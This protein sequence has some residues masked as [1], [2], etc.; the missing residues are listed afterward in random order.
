MTKRCYNVSHFERGTGFPLGAC[1]LERNRVQFSISL[2]DETDGRLHIVLAN[3]EEIVI[4]IED[5]YCVGNIFSVVVELEDYTSCRYYYEN[6]GKIMEDAYAKQ[7]LGREKWGLPIAKEKLS[8]K[9]IDFSNSTNHNIWKSRSFS[10]TV[11]YR[12]HVRGFTKDPSSGVKARGTFRG[13][14]EK[15]PYLK[16]LG[17]NAVELMPCYEFNEIN[18]CMSPRH[19]GISSSI[20]RPYYNEEIKWKLNYWGYAEDNFYFAPK[21]SYC[22]DPS[23]SCAEFKD[24]VD[25]LHK[26]DI[27]VYMEF[28]FGY[29][30]NQ[31]LIADCL[32]FWQTVYQIDGFKVNQDWIPDKLLATDPILNQVKLF[33]QNWNIGEYYPDGRMPKRKHLADDNDTFMNCARRFLKGDEEQVLAFSNCMKANPE[34]K[35]VVNYL[36]NTNSMTLM[37]M[38]SYDVKHND[39]NGENGMDGTNYNFSWNCGFEGK[40]RKKAVLELR[41]KQIK[42]AFI[43]LFFSQGTP[44]LLAGDEFG[45]SQEGNNNPYCLD[46][47]I[48]WVNWNE[49]NKNEWMFEFVK[50]CIHFRKKHKILHMEEQ[51]KAMDYISCG[52][53]DVS[54]HGLQTWYPDYTN[55]SRI[56]GVMLCGKYAKLD[57]IKFDKDFYIAYNFHWESHEFCLPNSLKGKNWTVILNTANETEQELIEGT[58]VVKEKS[59]IIPSRTVVVFMEE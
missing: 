35:S 30:T 13:L 22:E 51:L 59:Y 29:N 33:T 23:Q 53:P 4:P 56:L 5:K 38:V 8:Y 31:S 24:M 10:D 34:G 43:L 32:H 16:E 46:N 9:I 17:I 12:L 18:S 50:K 41:K 55:Y 1:V 26:N 37:D 39:A 44:L 54:F 48:S 14:M 11:I 3:K 2:M 25:E 49:K 58:E 45:N 42:N 52:C 57:R 15:I 19:Y 20:T 28:Y 27:E 36:A 21:A 7:V 6:S 47:K 40:T